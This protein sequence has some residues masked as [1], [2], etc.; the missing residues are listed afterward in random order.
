V[1]RV[2]LLALAA[3]GNPPAE[4]HVC[5]GSSD[6]RLA[7]RFDAPGPF[8]PGEAILYDNGASF[9]FVDGT[10][11]YAVKTGARWEDIAVGTADDATLIDR[12]RLDQLVSASYTG[13]LA[14]GPTFHLAFEGAVI[15]CAG[16]CSG[17][18]VPDEIAQLDARAADLLQAS[19][20]GGSLEA[21]PQRVEVVAEGVP[22][23]PSFLWPASLDPATIA[24]APADAIA[25][26]ATLV[27]GA[28]A[29]ALRDLRHQVRD[30]SPT[31]G[32]A[33]VTVDTGPPQ[34]AVFLRD[35]LPWE[36]A[37]GLVADPP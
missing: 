18:D 14:D 11:D 13:D 10:C 15:D 20:A 22:P 36:D 4:T 2:A 28:D 33:F 7:V 34:Y 35:A 25:G 24:L 16:G 17:G 23:T 1:K 29:A 19:Y 8:A 27:T 30:T 12:L 31:P 37:S 21:H 26:T 6:L 9:L 32:A 3:C 5:D